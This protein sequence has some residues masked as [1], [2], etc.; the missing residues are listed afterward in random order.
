MTEFSHR[1]NVSIITAILPPAMAMKVVEGL[2]ELGEQNA[3]LINARGTV[4][5]D[6]WY[7]HFLPVISPELEYLQFLVPD[8]QVDQI[9]ASIVRHGKLHRHGAGAVYSVPCDEVEYSEDFS[10]W[11]SVDEDSA[12]EINES[13]GHKENLSAIFCVL[14]NDQVEA[15]S[16]AAMEAGAHGPVI[17]Y[18]EGRGLRDRLGWLKIT[19][20][21][22]KEVVTVIVDNVDKIAVSEAMI[23]A[24]RLEMPGRGFLFRMPVRK[25]LINLPTRVGNRGY[26][27]NMQQVVAAID[28]LK[29]STDWRDQSVV[30]LGATG[31]SAGLS[32]FGVVDDRVWLL[33]QECLGCIVARKYTE[34]LLDAI[35]AGGARGASVSYARFI[36]VESKTTARG[37]RLNRE[38]GIIRCVLDRRLVEAVKQSIKQA[39]AQN[40]IND[41]CIFVQPV[42]RGYTYT[43]PKQE[44]KS[45]RLYR[46]ASIN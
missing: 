45:Q 34:I 4:I 10:L 22:Q 16:R 42:T 28:G 7:Q 40:G 43:S 30:E 6:R 39:C 25:G 38:S 8:P 33:D 31:K 20:R 14:Q 35:L 23:E 5:R 41:I 13:L 18:S 19:K 36:E 11:S 27:A 21:G 37:V 32:L 46:G 1:S 12:E 29:G 9:F 24:G 2:F 44:E 26:N 17:F 15:V 3:L